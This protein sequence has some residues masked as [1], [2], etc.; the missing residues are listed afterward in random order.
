[1]KLGFIGEGETEKL[2]LSSVAHFAY[3]DALHLQYVKNIIN[4]TGKDNLLPHNLPAYGKILIEQGANVIIILTDLDVNPCV[5]Q[6]KTRIQ[7][8]EN[9]ILIVNRKKIESWF[10][11]DTSAMRNLLNDAQ[12]EFE[13]P[14]DATDPYKEIKTLRMQKVGRGIPSKVVFAKYM[15]DK[16]GFTIQKA[17]AHPNCSSAKY[18]IQKLQSLSENN[19]M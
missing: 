9:H 12:F 13:K 16:C 14:E 8:P 2:I 18:Y 5:T 7:A 11:A 17:A 6:T 1:M 3:L 15:I 19:K 4:A 10:L